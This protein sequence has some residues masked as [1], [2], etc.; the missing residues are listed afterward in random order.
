MNLTVLGCSGSVPGPDSPASGYVVEHEGFRVVMDL[1]P[2]A[3][4]A[5]LDDA[6]HAEPRID[7]VLISHLHAD[8]CLDLIAYSYARRYHRDGPPPVLPVYGPVGLA[9]RIRSSYEAPPQDGLE[10]VFAY[11][12]VTTGTTAVG[13]FEVTVALVEHPVESHALR[14]TAG[15]SSLVYSGDTGRSEALVQLARDCDLLLCEA[16][17]E[18]EPAPP[19]GIHLTGRDAGEHASRAGAG[20]LVLTHLQPFTDPAVI[21]A[22]ARET[23]P[24]PVDL[25]RCGSVY[26]F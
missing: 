6:A 21:A 9:D 20:R 8:H 12:V 2:G 16:S 17:W 13:P 23:Y 14:L 4:G 7:A 19:P 18:S 10:D 3:A 11:T 24:G 25:A 26:E 1:G 15:G 5:L 22:E